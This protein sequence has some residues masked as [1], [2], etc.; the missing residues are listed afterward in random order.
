M[1]TAELSEHPL[2]MKRLSKDHEGYKGAEAQLEKQREL[3]K[4]TTKELEA[5]EG[6]A[7][8]EGKLKKKLE[9][10]TESVKLLEDFFSSV[11]KTS[12][13]VHIYY[14]QLGMV[15]YNRDELYGIMDVI[16][17]GIFYFMSN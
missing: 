10:Q 13:L 11:H 1:S 2:I 15:K 9:R 4:N 6:N 8:L 12:S 3:V 17:E 5:A 16:G 7:E 14:K